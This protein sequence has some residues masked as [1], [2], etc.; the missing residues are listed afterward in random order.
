MGTAPS[1][2]RERRSRL[3]GIIEG[4]VVA[5]LGS[6]VYEVGSF[7]AYHLLQSGNTEL[8]LPVWVYLPYPITLIITIA[9]LT[10]LPW[11]IFFN[12]KL[13][14]NMETLEELRA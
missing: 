13:S 5:I 14:M 6:I 2:K 10:R 9:V 8:S 4:I 7:L 12:S 3:E 1:V 11:P